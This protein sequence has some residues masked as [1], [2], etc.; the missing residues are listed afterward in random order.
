MKNFRKITLGL[1]GATILSLGLYACSNDDEPTVNEGLNV[2]KTN[3]VQGKITSLNYSRFIE[4]EEFLRLHKN[5]GINIE[6]LNIEDFSEFGVTDNVK[7]SVIRLKTPFKGRI[8]LY[9]RSNNEF[10]AF[11]EDITEYNEVLG[12]ITK[13]YF[14]SKDKLMNIKFRPVDLGKSKFMKWNIDQ[15]F[16]TNTTTEPY[17]ICV[18]RVY[19]EAKK[20]CEADP[21]C[22]TLCDFTPCHTSML[23]AAAAVCVK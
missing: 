9:E 18:A 11:Y 10:V 2:E 8:W 19:Q 3:D 6:D 13:V 1:L 17:L 22:D 20:A 14:S 7:H 16:E 12:G 21:I 4:S 5:F 15:V 23:I